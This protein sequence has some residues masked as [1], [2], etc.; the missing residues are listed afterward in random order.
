MSL[1]A[2]V[3]TS[4]DTP[5]IQ[6]TNPASHPIAQD[7]P[8]L[9]S[10][11][12]TPAPNAEANMQ[13][14]VPTEPPAVA[15]GSIKHRRLLIGAVA[16]FAMVTVIGSY[17]VIEQKRAQG[18]TSGHAETNSHPSVT[19]APTAPQATVTPDVTPSGTSAKRRK[20]ARP[21][22]PISRPVEDSAFYW[23]KQ[24]EQIGDRGAPSLQKRILDTA[25]RQLQVYR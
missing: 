25:M 8:A 4:M 20:S 12:S 23:A 15:P 11:G 5:R 13:R 7:M 1:P 22:A 17:R 6:G 19:G 9:P 2:V 16:V 21:R 14:M 10:S 3:T 24:A 18:D